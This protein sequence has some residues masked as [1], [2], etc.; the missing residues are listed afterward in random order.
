MNS[1]DAVVIETDVLVVGGGIGG[2]SAAATC[3]QAGLNVIV[4]ECSDEIGGSSA[5]SEGFVWTARSL[6]DFRKAD[7]LGDTKLF[8]PVLEGRI[9][10]VDWVISLGVHVEGERAMFGYGI[11]N[12]VD[13]PGFFKRTRASVESH[14]GYVLCRTTAEKLL[15][16]D[17][18]VSG[19]I[20]A[21]VDSEG[22]LIERATITAG[23]TI[24]ATGGFHAE[25][26]QRCAYGL[27]NARSLL[28]RGNL[29]NQG[30]GL[31]LALSAGATTSPR[32]DGFYGHAFPSPLD[33]LDPAHFTTMAQYQVRRSILLDQHGRRFCDESRGYSPPAMDIARIGS[34]I[35]IWDERIHQEA[36]LSPLLSGMEI[37]VDRF[38]VA[39]EHGA[40][41]AK[42]DSL[43]ALASD[44]KGWG[45]PLEQYDVEVAS[46]NRAMHNG[47]STSPDR[48]GERQAIEEPPF[49][50]MEVQASI[51]FTY[52]GVAA[53]SSGCVL[54]KDGSTIPNLYAIGVDA[55]GINVAGYTGGL[56]RGLV[57]G[58]T[59]GRRLAGSSDVVEAI[60][61]V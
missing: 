26:T 24:L 49:Y 12:Q 56:I 1:A 16:D 59:V 51:T 33:R 8:L 15:I 2:M 11:G 60:E 10:A 61:K 40:H 29:W 46:F 57:Q 7:P 18:A 36:V 5:M 13:M 58:R 50:A 37:G 54:R 45:H 27:S 9:E 48:S 4:L 34:A 28:V 22:T 52:G 31:R 35:M 3:A 53:D 21:R 6:E 41:C 55:G 19:C 20:A 47:T 32:M 43:I 30:G 23:A 44:I 14:G 38:M 17:T 39:R 25:G 42:R